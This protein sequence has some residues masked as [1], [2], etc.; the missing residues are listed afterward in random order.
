MNGS[1]YSGKPWLFQSLRNVVSG[2]RKSPK[3]ACHNDAS[4]STLFNT[5]GA[6]RC[7]EFV[8]D[9]GP[10]RSPRDQVMHDAGSSRSP[11]CEQFASDG[12]FIKSPR[13]DQ[14]KHNRGSSRSSRYE[15]IVPRY[16][17][18]KHDTGSSRSPHCDHSG[19]ST[20]PMC[21]QVVH[22]CG[23]LQ[24]RNQVM[25]DHSVSE[26]PLYNQVKHDVGQLERGISN[27][28]LQ[29]SKPPRMSLM[30][31]LT[32]VT[33]MS[34][35]LTDMSCCSVHSF[36]VRREIFTDD[37]D[38]YSLVETVFVPDSDNSYSDND[39]G[40]SGDDTQ[41]YSLTCSCFSESAR[42]D[43]KSGDK[44]E[45]DCR[46]STL[47]SVPPTS[48]S[49]DIQE[50]TNVDLRAKLNEFGESPGPI[51]ITT[52]KIYE[53]KLMQLRHD[54]AKTCSTNQCRGEMLIN[55]SP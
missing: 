39:G 43:W 51:V 3:F 28:E 26:F 21:R 9:S 15:Q 17:Q 44:T 23:S 48:V 12:G 27:I 2:D 29:P 14:V 16:D 31:E 6:L 7:D 45:R 35:L 46:S 34:S 42:D 19:P 54:G 37:E 52:R 4:S 33:D 32:H 1:S 36:H 20:S 30:S 50:L 49:L 24:Q 55:Y 13:C 47:A 5:V 25:G 10:L 11:Q 38:G 8:L 22:D 41:S 18:I 40:Q 53:R